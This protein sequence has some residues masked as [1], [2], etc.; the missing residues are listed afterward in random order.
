METNYKNPSITKV[1]V[2]PYVEERSLG[3]FKA[4][5]TDQIC[6]KKFFYR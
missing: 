5:F 1:V 6:G 4:T 3:A 2:M